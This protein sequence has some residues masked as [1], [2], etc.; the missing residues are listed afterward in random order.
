MCSTNNLLFY[1]NLF[2][3]SI[4]TVLLG[5]MT[6]LWLKMVSFR[7]NLNYVIGN[8]GL[9]NIWWILHCK[10]LVLNEKRTKQFT[11]K[12]QTQWIYTN[13]W[14]NN[15]TH[16]QQLESPNTTI[17]HLCSAWT[18]RN[19]KCATVNI[20]SANLGLFRFLLRTTGPYAISTK[21]DTRHPYSG[22]LFIWKA[23]QFYKW[24]WLLIN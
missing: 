3:Q 5:M 17:K 19:T 18:Y 11:F 20:Y 21:I 4:Q 8:F 2:R 14:W 6:Y 7:M 24:N 16:L 10:I 23:I 22:S 12:F 1:L 15:E 9:L 13:K